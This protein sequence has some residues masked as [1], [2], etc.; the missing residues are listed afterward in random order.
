MIAAL[1]ANTNMDM[2]ENNRSERI[3]DLETHFNRAIEM[4]YND[5]RNPDA[6][7]IDWNNPFWAAARRAY[8]RKN[9]EIEG[10]QGNNSVGE[11]LHNEGAT[12]EAPQK[13]IEVDQ[14]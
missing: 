10:A 13:K 6:E 12:I 4:I 3:K 11:V 9:I 1:Y 7:E 5:G 14:N 2:K 8:Q